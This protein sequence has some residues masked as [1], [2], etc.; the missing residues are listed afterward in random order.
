MVAI[1]GLSQIT[2]QFDAVAVDQYGVLHDGQAAFTEA[3][4]CMQTLHTQGVPVVALTNSGKRAAYNTARLERL[5]FPQH[6]F[7]GVVSSGELAR[8]QLEAMLGDGRLI[9]GSTVVV[10]TRDREAGIVD[11][12]PVKAVSID[13]TLKESPSLLLIAGVEPERYTREDYLNA[14]RSLAKDDVPAICAAPDQTIYVDGGHAFGPGVVADDYLQAG[15][16]MTVLGKPSRAMFD[17]ALEV[18]GSP[19]AQRVLM[20]GDSPTHDI[21]GAA[22]VGMQTL[23]ITSGVQGTLKGSSKADYELRA[24]RW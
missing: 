6:L 20:I 22:S 13:A 14:I 17:A 11:D 10:L 19:P 9:P 8:Q 23:L 1:N 2:E 18:L 16:R 3:V 4:R 5:G 12:L 21:A 24:L 7:R 15:G